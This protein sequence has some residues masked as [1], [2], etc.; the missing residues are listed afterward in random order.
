MEEELG[1]LPSGGVTSPQGFLAGATRAGIK[2]ADRRRLDL[3]LLFSEV[4]ATVAGVFTTNKVKAAPVL[5]DE[6][7]VKGGRAQAVVVNS[8]CANA[9]TGEK[10]MADAV[11]MAELAA[12]RLGI[13]GG[14]VLVAST[15]VIGVPLPMERIRT[16]M[17]E[18]TLSVE[19]GHD[20]ARAIMTT[21]TVP[22]EVAVRAGGFTVG[23][24]AKG[25]GMIHPQLATMLAFITTDAPVDAG[26]LR[27]ALRRAVDMSFNM[28]SV[29]GDSSTNDTA[30]IFANGMSGGEVIT[31]ESPRAG[32]FQQALNQVCMHLA[33]E[34]ARDGE[35]ASRLIEVRVKGAG[36]LAEAR[37]C[38][39]T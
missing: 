36:S 16:A 9:C 15:G 2:Y 31:A 21:D 25:S 10:G 27:R 19:G 13:A 1:F 37:S 39:R 11:E 32:I 23:G 28:V 4:P 26:F 38:A 18:I 33:R 3:A 5:L 34:M 20:F 17:G 14:D 35:G 30:V 7:R 8:G 6:K 12:R 24:V 29:D 22:K